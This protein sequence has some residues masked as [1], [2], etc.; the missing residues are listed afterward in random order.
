[1]SSM[2][3]DLLARNT[4]FE[5]GDASF[6]KCSGTLKSYNSREQA[7]LRFVWARDRLPT[8]EK[9]TEI[10]IVE[11]RRHFAASSPATSRSCNMQL[12]LTIPRYSSFAIMR[13]QLQIAFTNCT[14][15]DL[16]GAARGFNL[17]AVA[18]LGGQP[19][20]VNGLRITSEVM[21]AAAIDI[22]SDIM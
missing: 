5:V 14:D 8:K 16:D 13:R 12:T 4:V 22:I 17:Q 3:I 20:S 21:N 10:K 6:R 19:R 7:Q 11:L 15:Y 1:M 9:L 18:P 2:D